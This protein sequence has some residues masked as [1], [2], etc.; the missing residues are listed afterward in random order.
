[1]PLRCEKPGCR[2]TAIAPSSAAAREQY[3]EHL[4]DE[5]T[6]EVDAE[7]PEGMVQV[8]VDGEWKTMTPEEAKSFHED[9]HGD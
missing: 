1:M 8:K 9:G 2:W 3:R 5:H 6:T 4:K 7:I